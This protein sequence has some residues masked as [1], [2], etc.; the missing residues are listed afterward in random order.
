MPDQTD[1]APKTNHPDGHIDSWYAHNAVIDAPRPAV[2]QNCQA[3]T[4]VIGGG[5]AGLST[6]AE[7]A[8]RG[9]DV[10]LIEGDRLGWAASGRNGG[11]CSPNFARGMASIEAKLGLDHAKELFDLSVLGVEL[12]RGRIKGWGLEDQLIQGNGWL[13]VART[14]TTEAFARQAERDREVFGRDLALHDRDSLRSLLKTDRYH[15]ALEDKTPFH[16]QPLSY[17]Q[18]L[19]RQAE[20]D[21]AVLH[22]N[23]RAHRLT[24]QGS[25]W[26]VETANGHK[27]TARNI[28]LCL[29]A[30]G[31]LCGVVDRAVLP[32]ATYVVTSTPLTQAQ[33]Q[34]IRYG[35]CIADT[36]R[37]GDYYRIIPS[38]EGPRLLWGG[39]VTTRTSQPTRLAAMLTS[40]IAK[41]YPDFKGLQVSHVWSGLMGYCVHK[42]PLIG[43]LKPGL[44]VATGFGGHGL[45]TTA[46]AGHLVG[47]GIAEQDDRWKLFTPFSTTWGGGPVGRIATQ[48]EYWRLQMLDKIGELKS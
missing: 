3:D 43:E 38:P 8:Q 21:G 20:A 16:M 41:V 25:G 6:A 28:V 12:V 24:Q 2:T 19:A 29:S 39:R 37:A 34:V 9:Q 22:E 44:W 47:T 40:D 11:F 33:Q 30:Y 32:V 26:Q 31:R 42:M 10:T 1:T 13:K 36:R 17:I 23:T 45:N 15:V 27:I 48:V 5:L 7:L 35:G 4:L 46:M 14:D 18:H